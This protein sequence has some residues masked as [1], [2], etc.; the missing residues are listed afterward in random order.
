MS[1]TAPP[2]TRAGS[3]PERVELVEQTFTD[4]GREHEGRESSSSHK[5]RTALTARKFPGPFAAAQAI[6]ALSS[7]NLG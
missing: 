2:G 5:A 3:R 4:S 1:S 6:G 7:Q